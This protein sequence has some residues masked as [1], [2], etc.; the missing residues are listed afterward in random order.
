MQ[1]VDN[2]GSV[3]AKS[4][5]LA[6]SLPKVSRERV[7]ADQKCSRKKNLLAGPHLDSVAQLAHLHLRQPRIFQHLS[8]DMQHTQCQKV[9]ETPHAKLLRS[10]QQAGLLSV[11]I[12]NLRVECLLNG[13]ASDRDD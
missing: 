6:V 7:A 10:H 11:T 9:S 2:F 8:P 13:S 4:L 12:G 1:Q 3:T 5:S